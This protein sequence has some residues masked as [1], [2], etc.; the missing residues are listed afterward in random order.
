[1]LDHDGNILYIIYTE[2]NIIMCLYHVSFHSYI[3]EDMLVII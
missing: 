1:M 2:S 3:T